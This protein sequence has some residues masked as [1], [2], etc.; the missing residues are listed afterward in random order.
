VE[1]LS[2]RISISLSSRLVEVPQNESQ[3]REHS[4]TTGGRLN[5]LRDASR[6]GIPARDLEYKQRKTQVVVKAGAVAV[7]Q[8]EEL[9]A[10]EE[11]LGQPAVGDQ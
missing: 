8:Q 9:T 10:Q 11:E 7:Q 1:S 3:S 5:E 6:H 4:E 2:A